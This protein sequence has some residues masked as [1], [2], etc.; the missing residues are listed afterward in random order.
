MKQMGKIIR[1][2]LLSLL[3]L[4]GLVFSMQT[5]IPVVQPLTVAANDITSHPAKGEV[6]GNG[7]YGYTT[8]YV[9]NG[10]PMQEEHA[11]QNGWHIT[12]K[13]TYYAYGILW[14][15][16]WDTDDGDYYGWIDGNY[17]S[18]YV[19]NSSSGSSPVTI[20]SI[21]PRKGQV[22]GNGVYGYASSYACYSDGAQATQHKVE[23]TWHITAKNTCYSH[24]VT[25]YECWD[26]DDGDYYGWIDANYLSFYDTTP[27]PAQTQAPKQTVIVEKTV[28][29]TE[30][31]K[32]TVIV[33]KTILV[34]ES[35]TEPSTETKEQTTTKAAAAINL[36]DQSKNNASPLENVNLQ[37]ILIGA[38]ILILAGVSIG[39]IILFVKKSK[40]KPAGSV[41]MSQL[42]NPWEE[43]NSPMN[44]YAGQ[45]SVS[46]NKQQTGGLICPNC[47]A[48]CSDPDGKFCDQ[49]GT[50]LK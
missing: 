9:C 2:S 37:L 21:S 43:S 48:V 1:S 27:A 25:W 7:V 5:T 18:F 42:H 22:A 4:L 8:D 44:P 10:G 47:G 14:Y 31:P 26:T 41:Q 28:L 20:T 45:N 23:N 11:V 17:L 3:L 12:A 36:D 19:N 30:P 46:S 49:C 38:G 32:E 50:P 34:T 13:N 15:Q 16:C 35:P 39:L 29:V 40:E 6:S 33:E 24:G